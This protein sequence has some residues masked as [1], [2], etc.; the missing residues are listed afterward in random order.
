MQGAILIGTKQDIELTKEYKG[1]TGT[2][3]VIEY[4]TNFYSKMNREK[5]RKYLFKNR[6]KAFNEAQPLRP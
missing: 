6:I 2:Y 3:D 4:L 5:L 1:V